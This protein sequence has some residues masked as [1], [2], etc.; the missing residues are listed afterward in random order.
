MGNIWTIARQTIAEALRMK[1]AVFLIVMIGV[2]VFGLPFVSKGDASVSGAV[3]SFLVYSIMTVTFLLCCLSIFMCKS[4]SD[5]LSGRQITM[6]MTKPIARW[7]YVLGKW[8]GIM[9]LNAALLLVSG[10]CIY[11]LTRYIAS[12]PPRD[13]WDKERLDTQVLVAR[14]ATPFIVPDFSLEA[15]QKFEEN[16]EQ[17]VYADTLALDPAKEK[18]RIRGEIEARWRSVGPLQAR[19]F[20][21]E[22]VLTSRDPKNSVSIQYEARTYQYPPDEVVRCLWRIGNPDKE[23]A[24]YD[25]GRRDVRDRKHTV[26]VPASV[27]AADKTLTAQF[28]NVNPYLEYEG[29]EQWFNTVVF[30]GDRAV[31]ALYSISSFE[32]NLLRALTLVLCRLAFLT[33]AAVLAA[34]L[35]SF[36]VACLVAMCTYMVASSMNF[37]STALDYLDDESAVVTVFSTVMQNLLNAL[38]F[39]IPNFAEVDATQLLVEG[40][41]VT[42]VWVLIGLGKVVVVK[43]GILLLAAC[44]IFQRRQVAEVAV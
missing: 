11:G 1:L 9:L 37:I 13:A 36:P 20:E 10:M 42:L 3:Q 14:H 18:E 24:A 44:L 8:T 43:T 16:R 31:E 32:S 33:A 27:V 25:V 12:L 15:A 28:I 30:E 29:E 21:F 39:I 41:N 40:R 7:Q 19:R 23:T 2:L 38:N 6:L 4:I 35:F 17:G 5:D 22:D 34:S 26:S